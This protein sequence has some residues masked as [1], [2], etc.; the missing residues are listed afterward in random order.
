[1]PHRPLL[2]IGSGGLGSAAI[3]VILSG[4]GLRRYPGLAAWNRHKHSPRYFREVML[5]AGAVRSARAH[6]RSTTTTV[7][8]G[9]VEKVDRY[10]GD[11]RPIRTVDIVQVRSASTTARLGLMKRTRSWRTPLACWR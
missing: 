11:D 10:H 2:S 1:M 4:N 6:P 8:R 5:L 3:G 7:P 9:D